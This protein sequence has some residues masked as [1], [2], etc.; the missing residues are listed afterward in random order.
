[1]SE[2]NIAHPYLILD[3]C[4]IL[5]LCA[6]NHLLDI[7]ATIPVQVAVAEEVRKKELLS[8][9]TLSAKAGQEADSFMESIHQG[10]LQ[11]IDFADEAEEETFVNFAAALG[12][13][14]EAATFAIA[15]HRNW[16]A[17]TDDKRAMNFAKREIEQLQCITTP[18]IVKHWSDVEKVNA[19]TLRVA[20]KNI[21]THGHY[22]PPREHVLRD[23]WKLS[24]S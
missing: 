20:L 2:M 6:S 17:A 24:A 7:L 8:L 4:C 13:D 3:A 21:R 22:E 18:E 23:W 16:S 12:D 19:E 14:G 5:N 10:F 11:I 15:V 1:M 9:Q